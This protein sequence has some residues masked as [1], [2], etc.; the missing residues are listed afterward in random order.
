MERIKIGDKV[1][2]TTGNK[3]LGTTSGTTGMVAGIEIVTIPARWWK[4]LFS[5]QKQE[6]KTSFRLK[7]ENGT[8][9]PIYT[10]GV[11]R[12]NFVVEKL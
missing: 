10:T 8:S 2:I 3:S 11:G 4:R 1:R 5:Q 7:G 9:F 6:W 12:N